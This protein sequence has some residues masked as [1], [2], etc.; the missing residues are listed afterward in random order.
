MGPKDGK[1][2]AHW[3]AS[4]RRWSLGKGQGNRDVARV[5]R[6]LDPIS[7]DSPQSMGDVL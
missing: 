2:P 6:V 3:L 4:S 7:S 5:F 1:N